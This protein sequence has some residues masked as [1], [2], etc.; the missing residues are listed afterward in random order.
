MTRDEIIGFWGRDKLQRWPEAALWQSLIN[1]RSRSFLMDAGLPIGEDSAFNF[2][3]AGKPPLHHL[4]YFQIGLDK[5]VPIPICLDLCDNCQVVYLCAEFTGIANMFANTNIDL[6]AECLVY[7]QQYR[8]T[9]RSLHEG[10][11]EKLIDVLEENIRNANP[12][13]FK[14]RDTFWGDILEGQRDS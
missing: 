13:A 9:V 8:M 12:A 14:D 6:F 1:P 3:L 5:P 7:Y 2:E 11:Q 10:E 4:R